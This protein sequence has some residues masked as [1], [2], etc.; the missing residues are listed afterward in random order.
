MLGPLALLGAAVALL[1]GCSSDEQPFRVG[2]IADCVGIHRSFRDAELSGAELPLIERGAHLNGR[3]ARS[4]VTSV[5]IGG[6]PVEIVPGCTELWEFSTLT[7]EVRRLVERQHVD[8]IIAG[9]SGP[10]EVALKRVARLYPKVVVL[11]VV[12]GPREVTARR[13][14]PNLF[15]VEADYDQGV[16]GL[17]S[18]A[19]RRL[20]WRSAAVVLLDWDTGWGARDAFAAEFCS[21]GGRIKGQLAPTAFTPQVADVDNIPRGVDGVAVFVPGIFEPQTFLK[22]L[23]RSYAN[24]AQHIVVGPGTTDDP[25]VLEQTRRALAGVIG[26]SYVDPTRERAYLR[27][28]AR[29]FPGMP[30][31]IAGGELVTGYRDAMTSLLAALERAGGSSARL[32]AE[33][34]RSRVDLLGGPLRLD[35]RRQAVASTSLVRIKPPGAR[36]PGLTRVR[37]IPNVDQSVGGLLPRSMVPTHHPASCDGDRPPPW[38]R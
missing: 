35:R 26:S 13:P 10:D 29:D 17:A 37:T 38:A 6:R 15:R 4:G 9:G 32:P 8:A 34:A 18:Y 14:Q 36:A 25:T 31:D 2:V 12:H 20:G 22:Q 3:L 21:L 1:S 7:A 5:D 27:G 30:T 11:P 23:A 28:Y 16:A 24:P 33:L 19:Y